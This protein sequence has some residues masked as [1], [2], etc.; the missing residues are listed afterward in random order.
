MRVRELTGGTKIRLSQIKGL[1]QWRERLALDKHGKPVPVG[2][3]RKWADGKLHEKMKHG[4]R[5]IPSRRTAQNSNFTGYDKNY[6]ERKKE[7]LSA[8]A[9][10]ISTGEYKG[11][12]EKECKAIAKQKYKAIADKTSA[13][14]IKKDGIDI[15]CPMSGF[16]ETSQHI[17]DKNTLY[18]LGQIDTLI[19]KATFLFEEKNTDPKKINT[20]NMLYYGAKTNIDGE[21]Y[22]TRLVIRNKV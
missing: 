5:V 17:A 7:L 14:P 1:K 8:R 10:S 15:E 6:A 16:R 12:S 21:E 22:F 19:K 9:V 20:L 11:K 13:N 4:W 3:I 2:E 18:V